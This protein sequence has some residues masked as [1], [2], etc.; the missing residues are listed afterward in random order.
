M[1][2]TMSV[3][4]DLLAAARRLARERGQTLG[5]VVVEDALRR[6]LAGPPLEEGATVPVFRGRGGVRA[7]VDV[8]N[9]RGF[10]EALDEGRA[11]DDLR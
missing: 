9:N 7:G 4:D 1:R 11:L 8:L 10:R 5:A 2:T 6:E 3:D